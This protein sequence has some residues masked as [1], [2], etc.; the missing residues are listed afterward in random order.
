MAFVLDKFMKTWYLIKTAEESAMGES[1]SYTSME[2][3]ELLN[4]PESFLKCS[5]YTFYKKMDREDLIAMATD[6][7][8]TKYTV[9]M[10]CSGGTA[11]AGTYV[12]ENEDDALAAALAEHGDEWTYYIW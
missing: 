11:I 6:K 5:H 10:T 7:K 2:E 4:Q 9:A 12:A 8:I 3:E 1:S